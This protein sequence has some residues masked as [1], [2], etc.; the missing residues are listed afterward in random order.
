[1]NE[2]L[3]YGHLAEMLLRIPRAERRL[4]GRFLE[5]VEV[6]DNGCWL[7][8]G[9]ILRNG[10]GRFAFSDRRELA[11]RFAY[12][13][14]RAEILDG[15][16]LHHECETKRCCN[17]AHVTPMTSGANSA[18]A[19]R[20]FRHAPTNSFARMTFRFSLLEDEERR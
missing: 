10:Y 4:L 16:V 13:I 8:Q 5:A 15:L 11:H 1:M 7:W 17:P 20:A 18:L 6:D 3:T 12:R 19:N 14:L 9:E 2:I